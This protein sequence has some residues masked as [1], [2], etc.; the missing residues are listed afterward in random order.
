MFLPWYEKSFVAGGEAKTANLSAFG[1][2]SFVEAAVLLVAAGVLYLVWARSQRKAFHLP[3]GDGTVI[4]AAGG[5]AVAAARVA[6]VRQAGRQRPGRERRHPVGHVRRAAR[7]GRA[8]RGRRAGAG[9]APARA[10]EPGGRRRRL[11]APAAARARRAARAAPPP[12]RGH[13]RDRGAARAAGLG[14]R[15]P[16]GRR[17]APTP[18]APRTG[19]P[20]PAERSARRQAAREADAPDRT[21]PTRRRRPSASSEPPR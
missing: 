20:G 1:V 16:R 19:A 10:A 11:G 13:G 9:R 3:G 8:D 2:F 15:G 12:E 7:R 5:W 6:P 21:I 17:A 4:M 18:A 14:G